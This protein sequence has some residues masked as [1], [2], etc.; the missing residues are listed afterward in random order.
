MVPDARGVV[1]RLRKEDFV[2]A[3]G[4][5]RRLNA[6]GPL[7]HINGFTPRSLARLG[8]EM[9]LSI[10]PH[11]TR[12]LSDTSGLVRAVRALAKT[13]AR[14][15]VNRVLPFRTTTLFFRVPE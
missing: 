11:T 8:T 12:D 7:E 14:Q 10:V 13:A 1:G 9:G 15:V 6:V 5:N 2:T 3:E 4:V